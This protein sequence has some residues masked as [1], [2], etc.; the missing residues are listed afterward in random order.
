V[1]ITFE[2]LDWQ[3]EFIAGSIFFTSPSAELD[4]TIIRFDQKGQEKLKSFFGE[5]EIEPYRLAK[6]LPEVDGTKR[7]YIIG[8]PGGG[9]LQL[10][11][12]DNVLL[13]Y[14][15]PFLHYRTPTTGGSSGSPVFDDKWDLIGIH[16]AEVEISPGETEQKEKYNANE[17]VW[18]DAIRNA[19]NIKLGKKENEG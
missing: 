6:R 18:I 11:L 16:H 4:V 15:D 8:H 14:L 2:L 7:V 13:N 12:Q 1:I 10:S 9:T 3:E 5:Y 19:I 17:G